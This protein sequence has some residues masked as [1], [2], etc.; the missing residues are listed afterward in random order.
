MTHSWKECRVEG[1]GDCCS[2]GD[3]CRCDKQFWT[4]GELTE[5]FSLMDK[6]KRIVL[7]LDGFEWG[8]FT[9]SGGVWLEKNSYLRR[10]NRNMNEFTDDD[11]H[12]LII[13]PF[14]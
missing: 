4:A 6:N 13:E 7:R 10:E 5:L 3:D 14:N 2:C 8:N 11:E 12:C 9:I 1:C